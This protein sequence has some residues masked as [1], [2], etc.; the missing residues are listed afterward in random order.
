MKLSELKGQG[1]ADRATGSFAGDLT[2]DQS[3]RN[4]AMY[5]N[6][7]VSV[8][9]MCAAIRFQKVE[10]ADI[11]KLLNAMAGSVVTYWPRSSKG[12]TTSEAADVLEWLDN[13][14]DNIADGVGLS[15]WVAK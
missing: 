4:R 14:S 6:G 9:A 5:G 8:D 3:I 12:F 1:I 11:V 2:L 13:A 10:R 7:Q 15:D